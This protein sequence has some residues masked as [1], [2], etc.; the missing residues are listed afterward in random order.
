MLG[1]GEDLWGLSDFFGVPYSVKGK[2]LAS[3]EYS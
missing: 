2:A 1:G 3:V